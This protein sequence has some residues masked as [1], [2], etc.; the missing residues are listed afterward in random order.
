MPNYYGPRIVTDGLTFY[1]DAGNTKSYP[2]SGTAW[3]DISRNGSGGVLTNGPIFDSS[4]GG[5]ILF[6]GVNDHVVVPSSSL[7][8][9]TQ[10]TFEV[11]NFGISSQ[12]SSLIFFSGLVSGFL[13]RFLNVSLGWGDVVSFDAGDG[14]GNTFGQY[15]NIVKTALTSEYQGWHYWAFTK[16]SV[17][18][19]MKIYRNGELWHSGTGSAP[20]GASTGNAYLCFAPRGGIAGFAAYHNGRIGMAKLDSREL[21]ASEILQNYNAT[22]GRFKL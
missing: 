8:A 4:N 17:A 2:N 5:S 11:W 15:D 22:K 20:I 16:N 7:V 6:D 19:T 3:S 21:S 14:T 18:G 9:G 12:P 1:L 13:T 10:L